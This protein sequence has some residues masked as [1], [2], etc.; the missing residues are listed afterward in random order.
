[1]LLSLKEDSIS[2]GQWF[3]T[4]AIDTKNLNFD[5]DILAAA[6]EIQRMRKEGKMEGVRQIILHCVDGQ[7]KVV[8]A[9][10]NLR[11]PLKPVTDLC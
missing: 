8:Q 11:R 7:I 5:P 9:E 1:M 10:A 4:A 2:S 6:K 3:L